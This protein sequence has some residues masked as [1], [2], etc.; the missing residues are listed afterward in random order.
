MGL[1]VKK[2]SQKDKLLGKI[3]KN[4]GMSNQFQ[5]FAFLFHFVSANCFI[6]QI[7]PFDNLYP[8]K[9]SMQ[10]LIILYRSYVIRFF[11]ISIVTSVIN[12]HYFAYRV[13]GIWR[14]AIVASSGLKSEWSVVRHEGT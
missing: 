8:I 3:S 12:W 4:I 5:L 7:F 14:M 9:S 1:N 11:I 13:D 10:L 6:D 2:E